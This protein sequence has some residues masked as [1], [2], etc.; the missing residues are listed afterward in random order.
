LHVNQLLLVLSTELS[1]G[2]VRQR[3]TR[4]ATQTQFVGHNQTNQLADELTA[5]S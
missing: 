1:S 5:S 3:T 2:D 4:N